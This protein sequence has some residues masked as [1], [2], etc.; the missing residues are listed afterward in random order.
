MDT[1]PNPKEEISRKVIGDETKR[2]LASFIAELRQRE[3]HL[4][5]ITAPP[6]QP[7]GTH[8]VLFSGS[9]QKSTPAPPPIPMVKQPGTLEPPK[10][11]LTDKEKEDLKKYKSLKM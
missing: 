8:P 11:V 2:K 4:G 9:L 10:L 3:E 6:I 5:E 1:K 7:P